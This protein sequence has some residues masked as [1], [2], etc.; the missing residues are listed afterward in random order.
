MA[1][2]IIHRLIVNIE[3]PNTEKTPKTE[4]VIIAIGSI[5]TVL[6]FTTRSLL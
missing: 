3:I 4:K 5:K 6:T 1:K 2:P